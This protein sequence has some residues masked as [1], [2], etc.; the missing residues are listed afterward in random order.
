MDS[1]AYLPTD[2]KYVV[3]YTSFANLKNILRDSGVVLWATRYGFFEDPNEYI[4]PFNVIAPH[5]K[6]IAEDNDCEFDVEHEAYP[7]ILSFSNGVDSEYMWGKYGNDGDGVMLVFDRDKLYRYCHNYIEQSKDTRYCGNVI[8]HDGDKNKAVANAFAELQSNFPQVNIL[9][10]F[11]DLPAFI[12]DA[13][14]YSDEEEFRLVHCC[15]EC[16]HF[17]C[18]DGEFIDRKEEN[19]PE[20]LKFRT[21]KDGRQIPYIEIELPKDALVGVCLGWRTDTPENYQKLEALLREMNYNADL[22]KTIIQD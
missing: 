1:G 17:S 19:K 8:Y 5:L 21:G 11:Y 18:V 2:A 22:F 9:D 14:L 16:N 7:Y 4:G 13:E 10:V 15:Y 3:H 6:D 20:N 12:K